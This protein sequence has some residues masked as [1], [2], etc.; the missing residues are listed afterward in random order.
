MMAL[1]KVFTRR[2]TWKRKH[3]FKGK[4]AA[5]YDLHS[6]YGPLLRQQGEEEEA[7]AHT[8]YSSQLFI[9]RSPAA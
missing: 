7:A 1:G 5:G 2:N 3:Y 9:L 4:T 8:V 6:L